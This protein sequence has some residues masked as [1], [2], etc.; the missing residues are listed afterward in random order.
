MQLIS[1]YLF[2]ILLLDQI[3]L[4]S[5]VNLVE[6]LVFYIYCITPFANNG[7]TF[8][9]PIWMLYFFFQMPSTHALFLGNSK[10]MS[11][12]AETQHQAS[13]LGPGVDPLVG[14]MVQPMDC[15]NLPVA[16]GVQPP[17]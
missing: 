6:S 4:S 7:F 11:F 16:L 2:C 14:T 13:C 8:Y 3:H 10:S 9:L 15:P 12:S 17:F 5:L 1:G